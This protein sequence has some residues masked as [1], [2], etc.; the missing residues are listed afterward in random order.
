MDVRWVV[1]AHCFSL[2]APEAEV[3]FEPS[4]LGAK[5]LSIMT[6]HNDTRNKR[7]VCDTQHKRL[8]GVYVTLRIKGLYVTLS[9]KGLYVTLSVKGFYVALSAKGL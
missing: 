1:S 2:L 7:F 5:T 9:V 3:G 4:T 6:Q 8:V